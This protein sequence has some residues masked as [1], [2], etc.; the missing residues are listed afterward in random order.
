MFG[1]PGHGDPPLIAGSPRGEGNPPSGDLR[2]LCSSGGRPLGSVART[3]P[4]HGV[5]SR[6][7]SNR[8]AALTH[9]APLLAGT[10]SELPLVLLSSPSE[11]RADAIK[12]LCGRE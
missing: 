1:F 9:L 8:H 5:D 12:Q 4:R 7:M 6:P 3:A 11:V 2:G 10:R